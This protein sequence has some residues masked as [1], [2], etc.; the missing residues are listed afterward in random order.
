MTRE[1]IKRNSKCTHTW[2]RAMHLLLQSYTH[3]H[4]LLAPFPVLRRFKV[5]S[6]L[7]KCIYIPLRAAIPLAVPV[8]MGQWGEDHLLFHVWVHRSA[9]S[10]AY[11][12]SETLSKN[13]RW[14]VQ[15]QLK[16]RSR[17]RQGLISPVWTCRLGNETEGNEFNCIYLWI[18]HLTQV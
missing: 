10:V 6:F 7:C 4:N 13:R 16:Q 3:T 9:F 1:N 12:T 17:G 15:I 14:S 8:I 18:N 5:L 11:A 2:K